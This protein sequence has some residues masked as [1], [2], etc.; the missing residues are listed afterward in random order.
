MAFFPHHSAI[1]MI[2]LYLLGIIMAILSGLLFKNT[3]FRGKPIPFILE[4]PAYRFPSARSVVLHMRFLGDYLDGDNYFRI[5][6]DGQNLDRARTQL[7]LVADMES[8][9]DDM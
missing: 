6:Y 9:W 4:L 7:K 5:H 2:S 8:K 3:L 1:V